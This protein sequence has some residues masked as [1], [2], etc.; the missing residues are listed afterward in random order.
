MKPASQFFLYSLLLCS[1]FGARKH[2][3]LPR[4]VSEPR[5][6]LYAEVGLL[7]HSGIG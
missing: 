4:F 1:C 2:R 3:Q 6:P 7:M 5:R